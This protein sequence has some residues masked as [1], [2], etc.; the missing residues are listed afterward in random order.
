VIDR[1]LLL[2]ALSIVVA[3]WVIARRCLPRLVREESVLAAGT[4]AA[5]AGVVVARLVAVILDDPAALGRFRDLLIIRGGMEFWPGV[6]AAVVVCALGVRRSGV[7]V[8][9]ELADLAPYGLGGYAAYEASCLLRDGC[10]GP[11]SPLGLRPGGLGSAEFPVGL[12]V[13][14]AVALLAVVVRQVG[15]RDLAVSI[16]VAALGMGTVRSLAA[17][18]LPKIGPAPSRP[19]VES[20]AVA[21]GGA[22]ALGWLLVVR[23]GRA[24]SD[25]AIRFQGASEGESAL[26]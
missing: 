11:A 15:H 13:A 24:R 20:S 5:I 1:G 10:F 22:I 18:L 6:A 8:A 19:Q 3:V 26:D 16:V 17:L 14:V 7:P 23:R 4:S 12:V 2:S 9:A 21:L 25:S